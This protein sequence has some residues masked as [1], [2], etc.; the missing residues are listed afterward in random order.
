MSAFSVLD[1]L[2]EAIP[3]IVIF[4]LGQVV[5]ECLVHGFDAWLYRMIDDI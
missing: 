2:V 4:M 3:G 1:E 5:V